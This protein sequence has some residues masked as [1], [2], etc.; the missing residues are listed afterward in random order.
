M[1]VK[2]ATTCDRCQRRSEEYTAWPT[3]KECSDH[4]CPRCDIEGERTEADVDTPETTM[5]PGCYSE[6]D[7]GGWEGLVEDEQG[8]D[9]S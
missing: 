9:R 4:V 2:F 3:C 6:Q 5:C 7:A 8:D 1:M